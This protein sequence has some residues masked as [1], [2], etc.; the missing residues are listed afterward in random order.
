MNFYH[1]LLGE[2]EAVIK[3]TRGGAKALGNLVELKEATVAEAVIARGGKIGNLSVIDD[4]Y[5]TM[6]VAEIA[7]KAAQ[8]DAK[9]MTAL[10]IIKQAASKAQKY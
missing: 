6:K 3:L 10:K 8:G 2:G 5:K 9:A 4:A 7:N 1:F